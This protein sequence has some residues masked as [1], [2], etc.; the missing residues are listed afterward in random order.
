MKKT[1]LLMLLTITCAL[2]L[3]SACGGGGGGASGPSQPTTAV[4]TLSTAVTGTIPA[5]TSINSYVV[6]VTLPAGA[7]VKASPDGINPAKLVTDP[8]VVT[9]AGSASGSV[10]SA[11]YTAATPT[12]PGTIKVYV[13]S[14]TGF[15]PGDFCT[16]NCD[17]SAG[18]YPSASDFAQ[19]SLDDATGIDAS[20]TTVTLTNELAPAV[21]AA[22]N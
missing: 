6:T 1:S 22:I 10:F 17:I 2:T 9:P 19:V 16:I 4:L 5:G 18:S 8:G 12:L 20:N 11:I 14:G 3:F 21:A 13:S 7:T 15:G